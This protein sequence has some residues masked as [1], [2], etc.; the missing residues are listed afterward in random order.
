MTSDGGRSTDEAGPP[1]SSCWTAQEIGCSSLQE[2]VGAG[3]TGVEDQTRIK[4]AQ[5]IQSALAA[6]P[7]QSPRPGATEDFSSR[8]R[9]RLLCRAISLWSGLWQATPDPASASGPDRSGSIRPAAMY[10]IQLDLEGKH[11][12]LSQTEAGHGKGEITVG[13]GTGNKTKRGGGN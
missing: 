12:Y 9:E 8:N 7:A 4:H 13:G 5:L 10:Y 11:L 3:R 1:L 6:P 2:N